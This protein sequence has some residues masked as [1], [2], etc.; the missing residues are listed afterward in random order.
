MGLGA[1]ARKLLFSELKHRLV[2]RGLQMCSFVR[3][4]FIISFSI[5]LSLSSKLSAV[6]LSFTLTAN[7]SQA[8]CSKGLRRRNRFFN[9]ENPLLHI[10]CVMVMLLISRKAAE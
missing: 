9:A 7:R 5:F 6:S 3:W 2:Y 10:A 4:L 1:L 8:M